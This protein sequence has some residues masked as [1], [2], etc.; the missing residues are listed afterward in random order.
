MA[1]SSLEPATTF[2]MKNLVALQPDSVVSRT[3]VAKQA[4]TITLF[5]FGK[6]QGLSEHTAPYDALVVVVEG[7][8]NFTVGEKHLSA[9]E[10]QTLLLPANV[11]H[12]LEATTD[13]QMLLVMIRA[14]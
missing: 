14:A 4:G 1:K 2:D 9:S 3:L 7:E 8:A 12:A 11:P 6:G 13:F 10:G 5:A